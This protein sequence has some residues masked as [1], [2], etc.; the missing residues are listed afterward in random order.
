G[1]FAG[2]ATAAPAPAPALPVTT[3]EFVVHCK[4]NTAFC[5]LQIMA[6]E[7]LLEKDHKACPPASVS[8]NAIA[9]RVQDVVADVLEEDPDSFKATPY[10]QVVDQLIAYL[11][12]CEP[13]S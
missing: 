9:S 1:I 2:A 10:H 6:A 13:I 3:E 4:T 7:A 5:R 11:W 8:K 12:P